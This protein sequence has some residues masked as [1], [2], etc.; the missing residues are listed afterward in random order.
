MGDE[1]V[2]RVG[3]GR[4]NAELSDGQAVYELVYEVVWR[5]VRGPP[6]VVRS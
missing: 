3:G 5:T 2:I 6:Y 1:I 4:K